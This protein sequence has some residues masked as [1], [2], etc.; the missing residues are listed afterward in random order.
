MLERLGVPFR[1]REPLCDE[2]AIQR[3]EA[4]MEPRLLA[5]K[6]ALAKASSRAAQGA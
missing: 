5:E 4:G 6:L 3:A 1:C 2:A